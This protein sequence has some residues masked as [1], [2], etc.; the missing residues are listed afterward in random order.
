[1]ASRAIVCRKKLHWNG[2]NACTL[3]WGIGIVGYAAPVPEL[4]VYRL[5]AFYVFSRKGENMWVKK[6]ER[7]KMNIKKVQEY[8]A[9]VL[10][11]DF[12]EYLWSNTP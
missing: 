8:Y 4:K 1:M 3:Y 12:D 6:M 10:L 5:F 9:S 7:K 11:K 2:R